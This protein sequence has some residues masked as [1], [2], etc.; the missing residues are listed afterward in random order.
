MTRSTRR[1]TAAA[2]AAIAL[3]ASGCG[4]E[5]V[6]APREG[7]VATLDGDPIP[8][9]DLERYLDGILSF[10]DDGD[11][12][13]G[14]DLDRVRS[15]LF[16]AFL[17]EEILLREAV[18]RGVEVADV[19]IDAYLEGGPSEEEESTEVT[20]RSRESA[21]RNLTIQKL[22]GA[23]VGVDAAASPEEIDAYLSEHR[24]ELE[25]DQQIVLRSLMVGTEANAKRVRREIQRG[26]MAFAEAVEVFGLTPDQGQPMG[27]S[28]GDLPQEIREALRGLS[29]GEISKPVEF[30]GNV[31][32]FL[33]DV[34]P[35]SLGENRLRELAVSEL[36]RVKSQEASDRFLEHLRSRVE[37]EIHHENLP[38]NYIPE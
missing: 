11:P 23:V 4:G 8:L 38:F 6:G 15:R 29:S 31:Y 37:V 33:V 20:S 22:R 26:E 19:E 16:D 34:G 35:A 30:Q 1:A 5:E 12:L 14:E 28:L 9:S 21:R 2:L 7:A 36:L 3:W 10:E 24:A 25:A 18:R 17:D 32:L 13:D 27:V